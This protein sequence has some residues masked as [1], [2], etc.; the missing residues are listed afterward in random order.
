MFYSSR[1]VVQKNINQAENKK[2]SNAVFTKL[3][4]MQVFSRISQFHEQA[5]NV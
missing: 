4:V 3:G 5:S 2:P 1:H